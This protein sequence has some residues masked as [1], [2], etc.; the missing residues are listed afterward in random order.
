MTR[1]EYDVIGE[2][3]PKTK[4]VCIKIDMETYR[5][6]KTLKEYFT[7]EGFEMNISD[8]IREAIK[9]YISKWRKSI[10]DNLWEWVEELLRKRGEI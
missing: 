8:I 2:L 6:L 10:P 3:Y 5:K 9:E 1:L 7:I 4:I